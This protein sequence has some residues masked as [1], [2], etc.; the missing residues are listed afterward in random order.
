[1]TQDNPM[2]EPEVTLASVQ[3][4]LTSLQ[5][6]VTELL[7]A[8]RA[9]DPLPGDIANLREQLKES[10]ARQASEK[11]APQSIRWSCPCGQRM[12]ASVQYGGRVSKC[13]ACG[14]D[15]AVPEVL[16]D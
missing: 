2:P 8:V 3:A 15:Q 9:L 1:M 13:P 12:R 4:N 6:M 14:T 5:Q 16:A 11:R 10:A 7:Q